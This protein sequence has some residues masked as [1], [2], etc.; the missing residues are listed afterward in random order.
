MDSMRSAAARLTSDSSASD[1]RPTEPV[2]HQASAFKAM[3]A[4]AAAIESQA[5][6][7]R[8]VDFTRAEG[9]RDS[10]FGESCRRDFALFQLVTAIGY[11]FGEAR[12]LLG[13]EHG[14]S[15]PLHFEDGRGDLVDD[16][17]REAFRRLVEE[18]RLGIAG[19][20]ARDAEHLL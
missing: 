13:E 7:S 11:A 17:R 18:D 1:S 16:H 20:R 6:R 12:A 15:G 5:K 8:L 2:S 4:M 10:I 19:E 3:V 9:G 14:D